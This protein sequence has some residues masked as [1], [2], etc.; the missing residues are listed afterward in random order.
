MKQVLIIVHPRVHSFTMAMA[1]AYAAAAREEGVELIERD[2]YRLGFDPL[3]HAD[4]LPGQDDFQPREDVMAERSAIGDADVFALF[5][6]L[7][8][9]APPAMLKGYVERVFGMGFGYSPFGLQGNQPLLSNRRLVS[10][11]SSGAPQQW[12]ESSGAWDAMRK[13][14]DDH[15]AAVTG[16]ELIGHHNVGEVTSGMRGDVV[17]RHARTV[18]EIARRIA[19]GGR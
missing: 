14:F 12:V 9:N 11:T 5:Y 3:L 18:A 13:H 2:L 19:H 16:L 7:W 4:E 1:Q 15:L 10:F 6:P 17:D 8:F